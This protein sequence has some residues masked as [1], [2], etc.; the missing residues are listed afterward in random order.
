[1]EAESSIMGARRGCEIID[2]TL[3]DSPDVVDEVTDHNKGPYYM[4]DAEIA[5]GM[6]LEGIE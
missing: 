1:M 2:L 4:S 6:Y 5:Y 3:D